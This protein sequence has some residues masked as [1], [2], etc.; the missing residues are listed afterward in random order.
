L[1]VV[2]VGV[3]LGQ[4][5]VVEFCGFL[6]KGLKC[7]GFGVVEFCENVIKIKI[8]YFNKIEKKFR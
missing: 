5:C 4:R 1:N 3:V 6:V 7:F 8:D 2:P